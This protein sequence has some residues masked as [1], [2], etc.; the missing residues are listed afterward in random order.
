MKRLVFL[1]VFLSIIAGLYGLDKANSITIVEGRREYKILRE[2]KSVIIV[3]TFNDTKI[4]GKPLDE[5]VKEKISQGFRVNRK[6]MVE[7]FYDSAKEHA[8]DGGSDWNMVVVDQNGKPGKKK[9]AI[10][11]EINY[12]DIVS[13]PPV[14]ASGSGSVKIYEASAPDTILYRGNIHAN[15]GIKGKPIPRVFFSKMGF[16]FVR[17]VIN[18]LKRDIEEKDEK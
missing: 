7:E 2:T 16:G 10:V 14:M 12:D 11:I 5:Y 8:R 6:K 18:F 3:F 4:Y 17:S 1:T 9:G 15:I 13:I